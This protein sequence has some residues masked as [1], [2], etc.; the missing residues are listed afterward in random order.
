MTFNNSLFDNLLDVCIRE[1]I[2]RCMFGVIVRNEEEK[3]N[4]DNGYSIARIN[5]LECNHFKIPYD[6]SPS[7]WKVESF[8][9][10]LNTIPETS[11][12]DIEQSTIQEYCKSHLNIYGFITH[13]EYPSYYVIGRPFPFDFQFLHIF[14]S[15]KLLEYQYYM[16][17][18]HNLIELLRK[19]PNIIS[20][21]FLLNQFHININRREV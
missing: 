18:S 7:I 14:C 10:A 12:R 16:D 20:R 9:N 13:P 8:I 15:R 11:Y 19:Y 5:N 4:L 21:G 1:N 17:Q 2:D 3:I 6:V